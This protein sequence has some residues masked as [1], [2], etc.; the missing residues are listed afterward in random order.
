ME[1]MMAVYSFVTR[2]QFE[3]PIE[4]VWEA[5]RNYQSWPSWWP[6]IAEARQ[7]RPSNEAGVGETVEFAFRTRLPYQLRFRMTTV[8]IDAPH[9]LHGRAD[10]ELQ[11]TGRWR[12]ASTTRG[13]QVTYYWD[14]KTNRWWM[15][16][17][18]PIARPAFRWNHDQ[19][20]EDGRCGLARLL[21]PGATRATVVAPM[22]ESLAAQAPD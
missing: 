13:T 15:N 1:G 20:I 7:I 17:L 8:R 12:L 14:V 10:G 6:S 3:A 11:G 21:A 16:L 19:V 4:A 22:A 18:A 5:I 2:W 9:N